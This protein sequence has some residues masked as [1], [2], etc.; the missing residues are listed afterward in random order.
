[1]GANC[2]GL[3]AKSNKQKEARTKAKNSSEFIGSLLCHNTSAI[4]VLKGRE[5]IEETKINHLIN[6]G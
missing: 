2:A 5:P 3:T 4:G 6:F 1:M